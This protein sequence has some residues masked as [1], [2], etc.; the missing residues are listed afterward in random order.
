MFTRGPCLFVDMVDVAIE[1]GATAVFIVNVPDRQAVIPGGGP[2]ASEY[3]AFQ[4]PVCMLDASAGELLS[5]TSGTVSIAVYYPKYPVLDASTSIF[6]VV[7]IGVLVV[8]SMWNTHK[9]R[10]RLPGR[11]ERRSGSVNAPAP[12]ERSED[13]QLMTK[14]TIAFF[15]VFASFFLLLLYFF[16][17][18]LIYLLLV[19]F[20]LFGALSVYEMLAAGA[21]RTALWRKTVNLPW[22]PRTPWLA[23]LCTGCSVGL[24]IGWGLTR[25][26][27]FSWVLQDMLGV[28][29]LI[30]MIRVVTIPNLKIGTAL[31]SCLLLYD[32]FFVFVTPLITPDGS[33]VMVNAATGNQTQIDENG[34]QSYSNM[35]PFLLRVPALSRPPCSCPHYSM[36]GFGDVAL[37]GFVVALTLRFDY[38]LIINGARPRTFAQRY[39]YFLVTL[40]AY[41]VGLLSAFVAASQMAMAQ[42]A[43]LYLSPAVLLSIWIQAWCRGHIKH[44][45]DLEGFL[46]YKAAQSDSSHRT[47]SSDG[48]ES[49]DQLLAGHSSDSDA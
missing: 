34:C 10:E 29:I 39:S 41:L 17:K 2:N 14:G 48:D 30:T 44:L 20:G 37:P 26:A 49:T 22:N 18:Y 24:A 45:K 11:G 12:A 8:G 21:C 42:P 16:Y 31:L 6:V 15:L 36:L 13:Q 38:A 47:S 28:S 27:S 23:V 35:M 9:E 4:H 33:S 1:W 3:A 46:G 25:T 19:G 32:V 40:T 43:L 7:A 5:T